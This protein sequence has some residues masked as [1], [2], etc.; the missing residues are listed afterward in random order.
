[1]S[2]V[3]VQRRL[4]HS[5]SGVDWVELVDTADQRRD[6]KLVDDCWSRELAV[7]QPHVGFREIAVEAVLAF[8]F[9]HLEGLWSAPG[10]AAVFE[11]L[12]LDG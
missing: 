5:K 3:V 8:S 7:V 12:T 6:A 9:N 2:T 11:A 10:K 4:R 1:M